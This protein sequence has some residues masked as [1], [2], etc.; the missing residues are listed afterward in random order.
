MEML[1]IYGIYGMEL[2]FDSDEELLFIY[3][4]VN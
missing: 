1:L 3:L 4:F 2:D